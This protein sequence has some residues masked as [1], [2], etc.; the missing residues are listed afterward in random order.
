MP[1]LRHLERDPGLELEARALYS[2]ALPYHNFAHVLDTL[3]AADTI[4]ERCRGEGIRIDAGAVYHALLFHDAGY[5]QDHAALGYDTK[6]RYSAALA[7][8]ILRAHRV[9]A[10]R[11]RKVVAAIIATERDARFVSAEQKAVRA[12]DLSGMAA[13]WPRFL[14]SSLRLKREHELLHGTPLAWRDWQ[15]MSQEVLGVYLSQEIRLTSYFYNREGESAF[16]AAVR[17][18]LKR[19]LST[20]E[21]PGTA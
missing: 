9:T 7:A 10:A 3:S 16:H 1:E 12:A 20:P 4:V 8:P 13:P 2:D 21:Q 18:N 6:E 11:I 15:R 19:L 5:H 17:G 14:D